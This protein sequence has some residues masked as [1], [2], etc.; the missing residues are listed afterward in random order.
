MGYKFLIDT[1]LPI[2]TKVCHRYDNV[3][4]VLQKFDVATEGTTDLAAIGRKVAAH[5]PDIALIPLADWHRSLRKGDKHYWG[6]VI[7]TSKFTGSTDMPSVLVV[8]RD[9]PA[10]SLMDLEGA[11]YGYI[12]TSCTSS[13]FPPALMLN[14]KGI[15]FDKFLSMRPV[16]A[17]Q[18]QIDAVIDG[19]VRATMVPEDVWRTTPDNEKK[20]KVVDRNM[21]KPALIVARHDLDKTLR[22]E[23]TEALVRWVPTWD[24]IFGC[25][26]PFLYADVHHF[27]HQ[28]DQ[29]PPGT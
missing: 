22:A 26:T 7:A 28:L 15:A 17:W 4:A 12:N 19:E 29:L 2:D 3:G 24:S 14:A 25:Y 16:K 20:A 21:G 5:E 18:G 8:R 13:Y 9:D 10:T 6:L 23:L 1:N 11:T 27:F